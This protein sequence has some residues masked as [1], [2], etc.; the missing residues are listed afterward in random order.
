MVHRWYAFG[1]LEYQYDLVEYVRA[2][3]V[4]ERKGTDMADVKLTDEQKRIITAGLITLQKS[5][6]R[7]LHKFV[8]ETKPEMGA[9]MQ[10]ELAKVAGT[11]AVIDRL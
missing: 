4:R 9:A 5:Y 6:Q 10:K 1:S 2:H 8:A 3:G 7:A 11:L